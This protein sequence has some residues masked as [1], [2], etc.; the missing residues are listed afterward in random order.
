MITQIMTMLVAVR[1]TYKDF[2]TI[3]TPIPTAKNFHYKEEVS[4]YVDPQW[5]ADY[6]N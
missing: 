4:F 2:L 1:T 3:N 5:T 6:E